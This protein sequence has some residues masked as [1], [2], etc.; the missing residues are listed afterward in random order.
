[1]EERVRREIDFW[2][3]FGE[4]ASD[5]IA[6]HRSVAIYGAGAAGTFI[7]SVCDAQRGE[8]LGYLDRNPF[9]IGKHHFGLPIYAPESSPRPGGIIAALNPMRAQRILE[10][11]GLT[12]R[13][14]PILYPS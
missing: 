9:K 7:L 8:V 13:E 4:R 14:I 6:Q 1:M 2:R 12:Q 11:A 10:E 3:T 5:F